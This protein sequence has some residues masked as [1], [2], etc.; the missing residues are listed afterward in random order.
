[1]GVLVSIGYAL[2]LFFIA[3]A[4]YQSSGQSDSPKEKAWRKTHSRK[5]AFL[6][7]SFAQVRVSFS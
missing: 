5:D 7:L 4:I 2:N 3:L 1:L 6:N